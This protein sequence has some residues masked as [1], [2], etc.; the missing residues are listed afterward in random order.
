MVLFCIQDTFFGS[1]TYAK[2]S[3][4]FLPQQIQLTKGKKN[5]PKNSRKKVGVGNVW[6]AMVEEHFS[7]GAAAFTINFHLARRKES[8]KVFL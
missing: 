5:Y 7:M 3:A 8:K 1:T 2:C 6:N 4:N